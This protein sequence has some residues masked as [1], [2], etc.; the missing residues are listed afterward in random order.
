M[1]GVPNHKTNI[2]VTCKINAGLDMLSRFGSD[3]VFWIIADSTLV[4]LLIGEWVACV[5]GVVYP[6]RLSWIIGSASRS[7]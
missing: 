3:D 1:A 5:V 4:V 6:M 2:V 7:G